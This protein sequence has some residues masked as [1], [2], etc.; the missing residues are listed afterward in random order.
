MKKMRQALALLLSVAMLT[1]L[2]ACGG[3]KD[4]GSADDS[5]AG[6]SGNTEQS[7]GAEEDSDAQDGGD[8]VQATGTYDTLVIGTGDFEGVFSPYFYSSTYDNQVNDLIFAT[9]SRLNK[10]GEVVDDAGH[11]EVEEDPSRRVW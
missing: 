8:E 4:G 5:N 9:V 3:G 7:G 11:V 10:D 6:D 2:T 1:A